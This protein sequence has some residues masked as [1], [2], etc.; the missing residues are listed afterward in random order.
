MYQLHNDL[1]S[2]PK[3][4]K[5]VN[6]KKLVAN[7]HDKIE[8]VIHIRNLKRGL[9]HG[10]FVGKFIDLLTLIKMLDKKPYYDMKKS[11][12]DLEKDFLKLMNNAVYGKNY[13]KCEKTQRY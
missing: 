13:R 11:K 2:L 10:F 1:P 4:M 8:Y 9:N 7:L 6:I 5:T 12:N 3:G